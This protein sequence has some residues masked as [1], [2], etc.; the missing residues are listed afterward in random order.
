M[1]PHS[2]SAAVRRLAALQSQPVVS[3]PKEPATSCR[4]E[5][6]FAQVQCRLSMLIDIAELESQN[7]QKDA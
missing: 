1:I 4:Y 6:H 2:S 3:T 5:D 7:V